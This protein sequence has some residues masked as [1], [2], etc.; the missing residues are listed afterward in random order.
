MSAPP[1]LTREVRGFPRRQAPAHLQPYLDCV[2]G[3]V[4][5]GGQMGPDG[6]QLTACYSLWRGGREVGEVEIEIP[7]QPVS[8]EPQP[9]IFQ[10]SEDCRLP[11]AVAGGA[12][13][14]ALVSLWVVVFLIAWLGTPQ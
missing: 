5:I 11:M 4:A 13:I 10:P 9:I 1:R 3:A 2:D 7:R 6:R 14:G 12:L 8:R